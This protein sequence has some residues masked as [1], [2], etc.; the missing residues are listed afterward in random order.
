MKTPRP[1]FSKKT[2]PT[3]LTLL[4]IA[5]LFGW[6]F[7]VGGFA[8]EVLLP[9]GFSREVLAG[10]ELPEPMDITFA[11]DGAL[12]V[13]GRNGQLWRLEPGTRRMH[14]IGQVS[15]DTRGD[16]GLHGIAL[17]PDFGDAGGDIFLFHHAT[18]SP[19]GKYRSKVSRWHV[20]GGGASAR[21]DPDSEKILLEFDGEE[22][23]QHVGGALLAHPVERLLY[24]TTGD[25]NMIVN[26]RRYCGDTNNQ[27]LFPGDLR[28]KVLRIGFDGSIPSGNPFVGKPGARGEVFDVGHRQP[29]QLSYDPES[30]RLLLA[31]NGG[32]ESDDYEEVNL[33]RPGANNGWPHV[34]G[35]GFETL[36]R[37]NR[38]PG[39]DSPWFSYKR[40]TGSSCTG[41]IIYRRGPAGAFPDRFDGGL[42]YCDYNRKSVRFA[43]IESDSGKPGGTEPFVQNLPGGP[44]A[45]R[46]G[47]DGALYLVEY[48]GWFQPS[49]NDCVSRIVWKRDR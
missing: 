47:P 40:N 38:V 41:A 48:G 18:N 30:K 37:T 17:H 1:D 13:T 7:S 36:T 44:I 14:L 26:L 43:R 34:F 32:D 31:E 24:V 5:S 8:A 9:K 4:G 29:W 46:Q 19:Q 21:L 39:F 23:G 28:G 49:A 22:S 6:M 25:N 35:D 12:W 10:S 3:A 45:L 2:T 20:S 11:P 42:F 16:R 33:V 15:T 27:A